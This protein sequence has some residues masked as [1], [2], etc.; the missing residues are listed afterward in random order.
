MGTTARIHE[1]NVIAM[2]N[3]NGGNG[4]KGPEEEGEAET[5]PIPVRTDPGRPTP[6]QIEEHRSSSRI[7]CG[8]VAALKDEGWES[9]MLPLV[10]VV[11][12]TPRQ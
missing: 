3:A 1:G 10:G 2:N 12:E 11:G 4:D 7:G 9:S 8:A 6:E 5:D